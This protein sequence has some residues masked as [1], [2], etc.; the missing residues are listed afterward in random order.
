MPDNSFQLRYK[1]VSFVKVESE[2]GM[3]PRSSLKFK[4]TPVSAESSAIASGINPVSNRPCN[5]MFVTLP[6]D[7]RNNHKISR[8]GMPLLQPENL[9]SYG[10]N[11]LI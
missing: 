10:K 8:Q 6:T 5:E 2:G 3:P 11:I 9:V 4:N 1:S 7:S